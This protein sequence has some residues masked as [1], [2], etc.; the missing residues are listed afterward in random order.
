MNSCSNSY[1]KTYGQKGECLGCEAAGDLSSSYK[2]FFFLFFLFYYKHVKM[3]NRYCDSKS[4]FVTLYCMDEKKVTDRL[5][6]KL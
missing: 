1:F 2:G 5:C 4:D 3:H 6:G